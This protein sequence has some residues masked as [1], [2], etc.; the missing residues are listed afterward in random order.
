LRP[1]RRPRAPA[2]LPVPR[3]RDATRPCR[4][5]T[6]L[7]AAGVLVV[8]AAA[9]ATALAR[10]TVFYDLAPAIAPVIATAPDAGHLEPVY[11]NLFQQG[12]ATPVLGPGRLAAKVATGPGSLLTPR[13]TASTPPRWPPC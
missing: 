6:A 8:G 10:E 1:D 2:P 5:S 4:L 3:P 12:N 7:L 9:P 11:D 13:S